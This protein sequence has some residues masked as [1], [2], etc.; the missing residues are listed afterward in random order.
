VRGG[1]TL[2]V[3]DPDS[4]LVAAGQDQSFVDSLQL[5]NG[6]VLPAAGCPLAPLAAIG[7]VQP[8]GGVLLQPGF[9]ETGCFGY[10]GYYYL[11]VHPTGAGTVIEMGGPQIWT[12]ANLTRAN[13]SFLAAALLAPR[14]GGSVTLIGASRVGSGNSGLLGLIS[15]RLKETFWVLVVAFVLVI[16]WRGRRLGRPVAEV[17][18]VE[19]PGSELIAATGNLMHEGGH[20]ARAALI[21]RGDLRRRAGRRLGIPRQADPATVAAMAARRTGVSEAVMLGALTGPAPQSDAELVHLAETIDGINEE[22]SG[23]R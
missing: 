4:Q 10:D 21:L 14:P 20:R 11:V 8:Q 7:S 16:L 2:V 5:E 18:P 3:A 22:L 23:A 13:N 1:H 9:G 19:L 15:P 6:L 12:N 17:M